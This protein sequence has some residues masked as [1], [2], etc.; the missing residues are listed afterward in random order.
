MSDGFFIN[1][2]YSNNSNVNNTK[3]DKNEAKNDQPSSFGFTPF[4]SRFANMQAQNNNI[5]NNNNNLYNNQNIWGNNFRNSNSQWGNDNIFYNPNTFSGGGGRTLQELFPNQTM[6]NGQTIIPDFE[7][8][9][10]YNYTYNSNELSTD[11]SKIN[12]IYNPE[13]GDQLASIAFKNAKDMNDPGWCYRG[14]KNSLRKAGYDTSGLTGGS[15]YMGANELKTVKGLKEI[16]ISPSQ[17]KDLPN[18]TVVVAQPYFDASGNYHKHGHAF[19]VSNG[20]D[21]NSFIQNIKIR[22]TQY[23]AFVP[24][25]E[26]SKS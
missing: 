5:F 14:V 16:N 17:L 8:M 11:L 18:G 13:K 22:D 19:I 2:F 20:M 15:A 1:S 12:D 24:S 7:N 3:K 23:S 26:H 25:N 4:Y 21:A 6:F 10:N 9:Q